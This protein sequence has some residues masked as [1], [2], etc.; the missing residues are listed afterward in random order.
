MLIGTDEAT[1]NI[2]ILRRLA[3]EQTEKT[4]EALIP[5]QDFA[6][7]IK[8]KDVDWDNMK[9]QYNIKQPD[10]KLLNAAISASTEQMLSEQNAQAQA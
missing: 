4:K 6:G 2:F 3:N 9:L 8:E 1:S 7:V 5:G 10:Y